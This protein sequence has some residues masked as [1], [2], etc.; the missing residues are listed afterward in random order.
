MAAR[1]LSE[2]AR[3]IVERY[4]RK[5]RRLADR[6]LE[7]DDRRADL[8]D[9]MVRR[10]AEVEALEPGF[11]WDFD[12]SFLAGFGVV[13]VHREPLQQD[14]APAD[15]RDEREDDGPTWGTA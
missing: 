3:A 1:V 7:L 2:K 14:Q 13:L 9:E 5:D 15:E 11:A 6:I 4:L 8:E 12:A 10:V